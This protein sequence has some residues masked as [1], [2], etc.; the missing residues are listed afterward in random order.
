MHITIPNTYPNIQITVH[1]HI[2]SSTAYARFLAFALHHI[3]YYI[4]TPRANIYA[5]TQIE[6]NMILHQKAYIPMNPVACKSIT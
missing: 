5:I 1:A 6:Q 3:I 4:T 2:D